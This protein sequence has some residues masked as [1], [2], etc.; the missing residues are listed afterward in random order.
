[1][2]WLSCPKWTCYDE[3]WTTILQRKVY[4]VVD[5]CHARASE[6][7]PSKPRGSICRFIVAI[8]RICMHKDARM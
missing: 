3:D 6:L 4:F 5:A 2:T 8:E 7:G 1:M